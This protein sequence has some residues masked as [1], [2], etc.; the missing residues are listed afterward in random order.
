MGGAAVMAA[1]SAGLGREVIWGADYEPKGGSLIGDDDDDEP[2]WSRDCWLRACSLTVGADRSCC[3]TWTFSWSYRLAAS[4]HPADM[5]LLPPPPTATMTTPV[6]A[7]STAYSTA[8]TTA[9]AMCNWS[10]AATTPSAMMTAAA[11]LAS[12]EAYERPPRLFWMSVLAPAAMA[13]AM[14]T[15]RIA[16]KTSGR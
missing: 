5:V 13:A 9:A 15:I 1:A 6:T 10:S 4:S 7:A 8:F 2:D 14:I 11:A 3:W 12:T 16:T